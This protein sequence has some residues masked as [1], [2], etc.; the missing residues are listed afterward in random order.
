MSFNPNPEHKYGAPKS[1]DRKLTGITAII[2]ER[3]K[4]RFAEYCRKHE[5]SQTKMIIQMIDHCIGEE[6]PE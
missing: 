6:V 5:T 1:P 4:K 3:R 2:G